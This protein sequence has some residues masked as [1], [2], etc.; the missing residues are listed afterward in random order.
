MIIEVKSRSIA[1]GISAPLSKARDFRREFAKGELG[2]RAFERVARKEECEIERCSNNGTQTLDFDILG[3][4]EQLL[5]CGIEHRASAAKMIEEDLV[6]RKSSTV[7][8]K[9]G[10]GRTCSTQ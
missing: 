10:F 6:K 5:V 3:V 1:E 2:R 7:F 8:G 9:N 4:P